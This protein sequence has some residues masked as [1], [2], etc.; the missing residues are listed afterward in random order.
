LHK[1]IIWGRQEDRKDKKKEKAKEK[2][3]DKERP[4]AQKEKEKMKEQQRA[5]EQLQHMPEQDKADNAT[6]RIKR[7]HGAKKTPW[8]NPGPFSQPDTKQ[9][10]TKNTFV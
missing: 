10:N 2:E 6:K 1:T 8:D 4:T 5:R 3:K 9:K 7:F